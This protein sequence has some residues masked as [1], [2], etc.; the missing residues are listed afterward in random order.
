MKI[1]GNNR[2]GTATSVI[3]IGSTVR[4]IQKKFS[5]SGKTKSPKQVITVFDALKNVDSIS[6]RD[7]VNENMLDTQRTDNIEENFIEYDDKLI[8]P[9]T[10]QNKQEVPS[11]NIDNK[12]GE[13]KYVSSNKKVIDTGKGIQSMEMDTQGQEVHNPVKG[14]AVK[15]STIGEDV[16][17]GSIMKNKV[18]QETE[19]TP[20]LTTN[21]EYLS[22]GRP[23]QTSRIITLLSR[24]GFSETE[25][26]NRRIMNIPPN[27]NEIELPNGQENI[28]SSELNKV[29]LL[30]VFLCIIA[31]LIILSTENIRQNQN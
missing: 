19:T 15:K 13:N 12:I 8:D 7:E 6:D 14:A 25:E 22:L 21:S 23:K 24:H 20:L 31:G 27:G 1:I 10:R 11:Q 16:A 18:P 28:I 29:V 9:R 17:Q 2:P 3:S 30:M 5:H 26:H 4:R